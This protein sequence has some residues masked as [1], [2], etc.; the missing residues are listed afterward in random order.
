[1]RNALRDA[2]PRSPATASP[3]RDD[4]VAAVAEVGDAGSPR[5]GR[6]ARR[7]AFL[8]SI[9]DPWSAQPLDIDLD[10]A[11]A[12][13]A[14]PPGGLVGDAEFQHP[15]LAACRSRRCASVTTAPSTQ[16]PETEPWKLPSASMTRWLPTG[17][18]AEP[19]VSTTV[20]MATS[21]PFV[22]PAFGDRPADRGLSSRCSACHGSPPSHG[23]G[24][25]ARRLPRASHRR[26]SVSREPARRQRGDRD[27]PARSRLCTARNSST[28]GSMARTPRARASKPSKRSS[29]FSQIS[30]RQ[31]L[32]S[33]S[34]SSARPRDVVALQPVGDQQHDRA[35]PQHAPRPQ[36]VEL[37]QR[38]ADAR[39]A[40][41]VLDRRASSRPAPRR[42]RDG[43]SGGSDW[44]AACRRRRCARAAASRSAHAGNAGRC[45][46]TGS[47]S[48]KC[49]RARP[50]ADAPR[51]ASGI[52]AGSVRRRC[53][54][55]RAS[56]RADRCGGHAD[57]PGSAASS[58]GRTAACSSAIARL[59]LGELGRASSARNPCR[60]APRCR[61]R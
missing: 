16:P 60:A 59:R 4:A 12:G 13:Q 6:G 61:T 49:R 57:R 19:Q 28:C 21:L 33:R 50:A 44:S 23:Y 39:A 53:A 20:A 8:S 5:G 55:P 46:C 36:P 41:P 43:A 32:C 30:R 34:I 25:A 17:R 24:H 26:G 42:D 48:R 51:A 11:A 47:S 31:D 45:A 40:R 54:A 37:V 27:R 56:W 14:D 2:S 10:P 15:R 58:P 18:G 1:M 7:S 38:L 9:A 35:L 29:G 3:S 22:H 52:S